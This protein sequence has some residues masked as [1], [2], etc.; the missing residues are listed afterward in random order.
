MALKI[1]YLRRWHWN[2]DGW[3][4]IIRVKGAIAILNQKAVL[5]IRPK[6]G[7][8]LSDRHNAPL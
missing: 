8:K 5:C 6:D 2:F 1:N 7:H 4:S 3:R